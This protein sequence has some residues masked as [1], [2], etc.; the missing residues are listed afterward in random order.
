MRVDAEDGGV[1][2]VLDD[3]ELLGR[4]EVPDVDVAVLGAGD[5]RVVVSTAVGASRASTDV[6]RGGRA[7]AAAP[8]GGA[9]ALVEP[10]V[11]DAALLRL[12]ARATAPLARPRLGPS[13]S[14][15]VGVAPC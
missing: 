12:A 7:V 9:A 1:V 10:R 14:E 15:A 8:A 2:G 11:V 13:E 4:L 3:V 6:D 5:D